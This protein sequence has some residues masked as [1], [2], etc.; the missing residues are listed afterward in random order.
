MNT[1]A[2]ELDHDPETSAAPVNVVF[3]PPAI[4]TAGAS[5]AAAITEEDFLLPLSISPPVPDS[6]FQ[7]PPLER[8]I[9]DQ[10]LDTFPDASYYWD[11]STMAPLNATSAAAIARLRA[12]KPPPFPL[13]DKLPV[14]RRAAVLMLLYADK[15]GDLRVV[16]TM[17]AASL[18]SFSGHAALPGGK[19]DHPDETPYQIA[20]REAWEEIGLPMDDS[21]IP[22]PFAIEPLCYLPYSLARTELVVRPCIALLHSNAASPS[23]SSSSSSSNLSVSTGASSSVSPATP[24]EPTVEE[25]LIPRLDAKEV[26]AVFSA[27]FHNFLKRTDEILP[28]SNNRQ[29]PPPEGEWY[30]GNWTEW[31]NHPWRLHFFYVHVTEQHVSKPPAVEAV[32]R[33]SSLEEDKTEQGQTEAQAAVGNGSDELEIDQHPGRYKVWGMTAR[34][35]VDAARIAY[36]E[37]PEFEH[38]RHFGDEEMIEE[39][40]KMGRLTPK[41]RKRD[42]KM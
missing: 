18:R 31:N 15:K 23:A 35:L 34:M 22:P 39:L 24:N 40:E 12:Y 11:A 37:E 42:D 21:K 6:R 25:A 3:D 36:D 32:D 14:S 41:K 1:S 33:L 16:I 19:A 8:T 28:G 2:Q 4:L 26:A 13:W 7:V 38:N 27:P 17:R 10:Q 5:A 29:A 20:R 9:L 30:T